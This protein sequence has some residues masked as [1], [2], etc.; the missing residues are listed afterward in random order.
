MTPMTAVPET[1]PYTPFVGDFPRSVSSLVTLS[2]EG[3]VTPG[4][5]FSVGTTP[6]TRVTR[7]TPGRVP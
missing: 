3:P 2:S 1:S 5:G 4:S 6:V 7:V